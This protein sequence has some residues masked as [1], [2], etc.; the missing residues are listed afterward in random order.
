MHRRS[1]DVDNKFLGA[2]VLLARVA[3]LVLLICGD[4][5]LY[6]NKKLGVVWMHSNPH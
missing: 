5:L 6:T 3:I 2:D 1:C 4:D